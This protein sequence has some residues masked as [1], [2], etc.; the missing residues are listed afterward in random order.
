MYKHYGGVCIGDNSST[1]VIV[2]AFVILFQECMLYMCICVCIGCM[3]NVYSYICV[4]IYIYITIDV[5]GL[6]LRIQI[7]S[8]IDIS[9]Y[10]IVYIITYLYY[11]H[12]TTHSILYTTIYIHL[13]EQHYQ[14]I[15]L[16]HVFQIYVLLYYY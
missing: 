9:T 13:L 12:Y 15:L 8:V 2:C 10:I 3:Y 5:L 6:C 11:T 1:G 14:H 4:C 7:R 16:V